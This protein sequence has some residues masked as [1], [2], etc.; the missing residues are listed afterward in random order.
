[1]AEEII[2]HWVVDEATVDPGVEGKKPSL[3]DFHPLRPDGPDSPACCA[4]VISAV[5]FADDMD[6]W[7]SDLN[8]LYASYVKINYSNDLDK[9]MERPKPTLMSIMKT[10]EEFHRLRIVGLFYYILF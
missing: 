3:P 8:P 4:A 1:M 6:G 10:T 5:V 2:G 9:V 7:N